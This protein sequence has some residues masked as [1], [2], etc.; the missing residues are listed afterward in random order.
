VLDAPRD[1][2]T[3]RRIGREAAGRCIDADQRHPARRLAEKTI[4]KIRRLGG[5]TRR[6]L[7]IQFRRINAQTP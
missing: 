5:C 1:R 2:L 4:G 6:S 7:L 3:G